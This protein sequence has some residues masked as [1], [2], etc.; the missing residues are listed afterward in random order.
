MR[1]KAQACTKMRDSPTYN[2]AVARTLFVSCHP[3]EARPPHELPPYRSSPS[4]CDHQME[5]R[6][7]RNWGNARCWLRAQIENV[8]VCGSI[9]VISACCDAAVRALVYTRCCAR[10]LRACSSSRV[11]A[12]SPFC[13]R[14]S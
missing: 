3:I 2:I 6:H 5:L 11:R 9:N 14:A 1:Q 13:A 7:I 10:V 8:N 4:T 12:R